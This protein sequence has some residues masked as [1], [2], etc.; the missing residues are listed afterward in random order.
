MENHQEN[1][2]SLDIKFKFNDVL[3]YNISVA[4]KN[5]VNDIVM[6]IGLA[7]LIFFFYKMAT[8][9]EGMD[10]YI[11]KN[12]ALLL[13]PIL[14]FV[15]IPVRVWK[16]TATQMQLPAFAYGVHYDFSKESI[17]LDLGEESEAMPWDL[18]VNIV[19]TK[20]DFRLYVNK[21]SAQ[22]IPKHNM[23]KE[24]LQILRNLIKDS[25]SE[26]RYS[27]KNN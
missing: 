2:L 8:T 4:T 23:S 20:K 24:E 19:E 17:V 1:K 26:D 3:R 10:V 7:V 14:I 22:I 9:T 6:G 15:L 12:I 11:S 13:V 25:T 5:I 21:V 16:I 27:L 18:F